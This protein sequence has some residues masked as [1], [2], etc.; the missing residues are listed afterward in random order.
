MQYQLSNI[1]NNVQDTEA[2]KAILSEMKP[3]K[4]IKKIWNK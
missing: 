3:L 4:L 1:Q 2:V